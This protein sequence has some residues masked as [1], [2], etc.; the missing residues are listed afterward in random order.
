M[1]PAYKI[2]DI[3]EVESIQKHVTKMLPETK[4]ICYEDRL[5]L[6]NLLTSVYLLSI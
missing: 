6:L 2:K 1:V 3:E 4:N 5:S